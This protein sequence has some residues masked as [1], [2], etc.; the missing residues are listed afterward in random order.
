VLVEREALLAE[1]LG[2][3][4]EGF[5]GHGQLVFLGGEA[6]VGKTTLTRALAADLAGTCEVRVGAVDNLTTADALAA[7]HDALPEW[8]LSVDADR[9]G[10]FRSLREELRSRPVLLVLEDLHW[11]DEATL[12]AVRFLGRRLDGLPVLIVATYR[13]DE[14]SPRHPLTIVMGELAGLPEVHRRNV[15]PLTPRGVA[16][17]VEQSGA[18]V[19]AEA[20]H[21][22]TQGN[23]FFVTEVLASGDE[24]VPPTVR[25]AVLARF[26]QLSDAAAEIAAAA[27]ILGTA[28]PIELL[29]AVSAGSVAAVDECVE[30]GVLVVG[31]DG[32]GFRHELARQAVEQSL[33]V[34]RRRRLHE[35][36]LHRLSVLDPADHRS[37]AHHALWAGED[38][39]AVQHAILAAERAARLGAHREAVAQYQL[40][41]RAQPAG[42]QVAGRAGVFDALAYECYLTDQIPEAIA[43]RRRAL[44]LFELGGDLVR[45]GDAQRWLSRLSWFLGRNED[46]ERY[47]ARAVE[48][49]A[50]LGDTHELAMAYSN[51][52]QLRMLA[53]DNTAAE[54]WGGRALALARQLGD[55]EVEIHALNNVGTAISHIGRDIEGRALLQRSLDL[56]LAGDLHEHAAR[57]YTNLSSV[58]TSQRHYA[59]AVRFLSAG[60]TYCDERDLDSWTRYMTSWRV[61]ALGELGSWNEALELSVAL[62]GHPHLDPVS[63]ISAAA[64]SGRIRARRGQDATDVLGLAVRLAGPTGE[65]QRI[66]PA[67]C[68]AAEA[69][70]LAGRPEEIAA[71]T[72][73]AWELIVTH[74]D[75]WMLGELL[76]WRSLGGV[77]AEPGAL[78]TPAEPFTLMLAGRWGEAAAAWEAL[79][80]PLW[81]AYALGL[82]PAM[83]AAQRAV[84][85][86]DGLGAS[87]AV[88]AVLRSR[89]ERGLALP[90]RPRASARERVGQLTAR[91]FDILLLLADGLST[92]D[93]AERLVL[94]PRTV[95]HHVSAVLR[96]LGEP[97][98]AR[99]VATARRLGLLGQPA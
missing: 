40:A 68:A 73:R 49:L 98:R 63:A 41:L 93:L 90:R 57:A 35:R 32:L 95:E 39:L 7:V 82:A 81:V 72:Q 30:R 34:A 96:K 6:G 74:H 36:A 42:E 86:L 2:Y 11:A 97:T 23:A 1:L 43:A 51:L 78:D 77:T 16:L 94:S 4:A 13:H 29:V 58:A 21:A 60:I 20:L 55:S 99:A 37:L 17:L 66:G 25:D 65:L 64:A 75:R 24:A 70:W 84:G 71:L 69:A 15:A 14:V 44:E 31:G 9:L 22:R 18:A 52:A 33:S 87:A 83:D 5:A 26:S 38:A 62:L 89:R 92:A 27:A 8:R 67:A 91:E 80:C 19:D 3:A 28:A 85:I 56:A 76:W 50:P 12:D 53:G 47:A 54:H 10:L 46:A 48:N 45:V 79:G 88:E 61:V 59:D